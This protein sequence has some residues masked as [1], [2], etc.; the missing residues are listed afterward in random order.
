MSAGCPLVAALPT[1]KSGVVIESAKS[2]KIYT[3]WRGCLSDLSDQSVSVP[4][5]RFAV[6]C[7]VPFP[8]SVRC[9]LWP[10]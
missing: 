1:T 2:G 4:S 3:T 9:N 8:H 10:Q 5:E 6:I 7:G